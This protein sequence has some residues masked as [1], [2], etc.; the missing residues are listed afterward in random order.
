MTLRKGQKVKVSYEA[1]YEGPFFD[2]WHQL[3]IGKRAPIAP[4]DATIEPIEDLQPGDVYLDAE[5]DIAVWLPAHQSRPWLVT[6]IRGCVRAVNVGERAYGEYMQRPL[7]LLVR[8][9]KPVQ[10]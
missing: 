2:G 9:G 7:T 10:P 8:D 4:P 1:E 3:Q 6:H 5:G